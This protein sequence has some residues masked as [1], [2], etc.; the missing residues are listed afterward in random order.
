MGEFRGK[1]S[2]EELNKDPY[3]LKE[4][5][6]KED[7]LEGKITAKDKLL[8]FG[9]E[10]TSGEEEPLRY[11]RLPIRKYLSSLQIEVK[12]LLVYLI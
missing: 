3:I 6:A 7:S 9:Q 1:V 4:D 5:S 8:Q 10:I 12:D 11:T 2:E